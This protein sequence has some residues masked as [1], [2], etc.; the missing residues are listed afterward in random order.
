[1]SV[2]ARLPLTVKLSAPSGRLSRSTEYAHGSYERGSELSNVQALAPD[3]LAAA[4]NQFSLASLLVDNDGNGCIDAFIVIHAASGAEVT[5]NTN[6]IWSVKW[7]LPSVTPINDVNVYA[8]LT[9][10]EDA[11]IGVSCHELG[12][13]VF[14]WPGLYDTDDSSDDIGNWCLMSGGTRVGFP[15]A[16]RRSGR[17]REEW[18][19]V[20]V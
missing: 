9:I 7:V 14:G 2:V 5:G 8:F 3:A 19:M 10:P 4:K 1:M 20:G 16:T 11:V 12:H 17:E 18:G 6:D 13:L 15:Q